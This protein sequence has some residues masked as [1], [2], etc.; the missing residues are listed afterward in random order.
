MF[1]TNRTDY[2]V[3][4]RVLTGAAPL[5]LNPFVRH[6]PTA[7]KTLQGRKPVIPNCNLY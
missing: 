1:H 6:A 2:S 4:C 7:P 5:V 3:V